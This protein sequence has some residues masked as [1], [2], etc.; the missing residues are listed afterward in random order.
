MG[1]DDV[2][3]R[4]RNASRTGA[5]LSADWLDLWLGIASNFQV[6]TLAGAGSGSAYTED[7]AHARKRLGSALAVLEQFDAV[8]VVD[9]GLGVFQSTEELSLLSWLLQVSAGSLQ[10]MPYVSHSS[11]HS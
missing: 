3:N 1:F 5:N 2:R 11:G 6:R 8:F 9:Q 4:I 7:G 10:P